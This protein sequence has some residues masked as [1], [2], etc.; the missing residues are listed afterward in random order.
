MRSPQTFFEFHTLFPN[1]AACWGH[2]RRVRW[3]Q[4]F[5]CPRCGGR[6]SYRIHGRRLEQCRSCRYQA[7][8]TAGTVFHGTRIPLRI[9]F[10]AIFL[11]V[12]A[13]PSSGL[14]PLRSGRSRRDLHWRP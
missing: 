13:G 12:G 9:W 4:G 7:S 3:P 1:D 8:L 2:L 5:R 6:A 11:S 10:L 14:S